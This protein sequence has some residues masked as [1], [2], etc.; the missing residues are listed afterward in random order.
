VHA[1]HDVAGRASTDAF[2][3]DLATAWICDVLR[4][5]EATS[6]QA[7]TQQATPARA[8]SKQKAST[9]DVAFRVTV[10]AKS[11]DWQDLLR[12]MVLTPNERS[13]P[14]LPL[15]AA[16]LDPPMC[17]E[18]EKQTAE[19]LE[20]FL[21]SK[22]GGLQKQVIENSV[23]VFALLNQSVLFPEDECLTN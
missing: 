7:A 1:L 23:A 18:A 12:R 20:V 16:L 9:A 4:S 21:G 5:L 2:R 6:Q 10:S 17:A 15:A 14:V 13:G 19:L 11:A 3:K 22:T 8:K